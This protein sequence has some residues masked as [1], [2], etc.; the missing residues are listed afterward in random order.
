MPQP[1]PRGLVFDI[2]RFALHDG[3]GIRT[4]VFLKGCPLRCPWCHNPEGRAALPELRFDPAHC[5]HCGACVPACPRGGHRL[6]HGS[7]RFDRDLCRVCGLCAAAC[8]TGALE[9]C[10]ASRSVGEVLEV[11]LRDR[12]YYR[13]SG[14]GL[15]LS[16][17]EP[18]LQPEFAAA[19]LA[20][21]RRE[22]L[23][24]AVETSGTAPWDRWGALREVT[25]LFLYDL[26]EM[27]PGRHQRVIGSP[28]ALVLD[29]LARLAS[30]G[31]T[32]VV[33]LPLVPGYNAREDHLRRAAEMI[34]ALPGQP[35]VDL[36]PYH[37]LGEA[38]R[39]TL[40]LPSNGQAQPPAD[41]DVA[42]W[43]ELLARYGVTARVPQ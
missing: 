29:N 8:P 6:E 5:L 31:A 27:D 14:G 37:R 11:V 33:R 43:L 1:E 24:T 35:A 21:A 34:A 2:Q 22:G 4:T 32:V 39:Q 30:S 17:G 15:T 16:G 23:H 25:D 7:H 28:L 20:A 10:G 9:I 41:A 12:H 26:K 36:L 13:D 19:L 40:G 38:K 18:L 42:G 3:P